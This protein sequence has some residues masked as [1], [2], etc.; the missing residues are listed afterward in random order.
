MTFID[1]ELQRISVFVGSFGE[2]FGM[3]YWMLLMPAYQ[4]WFTCSS[5]QHILRLSSHDGFRL[6]EVA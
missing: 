4:G 3:Y 2:G 1:K 5:L 6:L